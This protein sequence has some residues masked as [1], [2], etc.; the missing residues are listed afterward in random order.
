MGALGRLIVGCALFSFQYHLLS[1]VCRV[2]THQGRDR[3]TLQDRP[4]NRLRVKCH[5]S[6]GMAYLPGGLHPCNSDPVQTFSLI[7]TSTQTGRW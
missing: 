7:A 3:V 4:T 1:V 5:V 6:S 2:S